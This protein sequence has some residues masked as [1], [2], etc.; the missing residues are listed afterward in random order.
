M[1]LFT[2]VAEQGISQNTTDPNLTVGTWVF[3][4]DTSM[5]K[6]DKKAKG[7]YAKMNSEQRNR[8]DRAYRN[9]KLSFFENGDFIQEVSTG[10]QVQGS[11]SVRSGV[12]SIKIG[13]TT[14]NYKL[15]E[16]SSSRLVLSP[17]IKGKGST[18]F[19]VQYFIRK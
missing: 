14:Y 19:A 15:F 11:W 4:Y 5:R 9:R 17:V 18:I 2:M 10:K 6:I 1:V 8:F 12:L 16:I 3:S 13:D 7:H